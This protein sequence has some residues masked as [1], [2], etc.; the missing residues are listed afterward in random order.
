VIP[1]WGSGL[2]LLLP[3]RIGQGLNFKENS[4]KQ[5]SGAD[6]FSILYGPTKVVP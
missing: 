3:E 4:K 2:A 1:C 6:V 5:P